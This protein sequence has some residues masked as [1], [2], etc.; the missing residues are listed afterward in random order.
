MNQNGKKKIETYEEVIKFLITALQDFQNKNLTG[1]QINQ[2]IFEGENGKTIQDVTYAILHA[3]D[4][5]SHPQYRKLIKKEFI[6]LSLQDEIDALQEIINLKAY[7][8]LP[9]NIEE[10]V[11]I[12][13]EDVE[14][15]N[16]TDIK[17]RNR[18]QIDQSREARL[19]RA[20]AYYELENAL[21]EVL[22]DNEQ[23]IIEPERIEETR[24]LIKE[25][26]TLE[27]KFE[28]SIQK[29]LQ[30]K[31]GFDQTRAQTAARSYITYI[32]NEKVNTQVKP[33]LAV[34]ASINPE[35][36]ERKELERLKIKYF[37]N[38]RAVVSSRQ[39]RLLQE[40]ARNYTQGLLQ[41]SENKTVLIADNADL[42]KD[43][44]VKARNNTT[45]AYVVSNDVERKVDLDSEQI[46]LLRQNIDQAEKDPTNYSRELEERVYQNL[47][48]ISEVNK[49][50]DD[51]QIRRESKRI[52]IEQTDR[53]LALGKQLGGSVYEREVKLALI[54]PA[55]SP[56]RLI[57]PINTSGSPA[58]Q[59]TRDLQV[60][61]AV[62]SDLTR[63]GLSGVFDTEVIYALNGSPDEE[64]SL[65]TANEIKNGKVFVIDL[66]QI[67]QFQ[68]LAVVLK[69]PVEEITQDA[70]ITAG[71]TWYNPTAFTFFAPGEAVITS[72]KRKAEEPFHSTNKLVTS[73]RAHG[74]RLTNMQAQLNYSA[75]TTDE[76]LNF[77][78]VN[79]SSNGPLMIV[80]MTGRI[81]GSVSPEVVVWKGPMPITQNA[82]SEAIALGTDENA[83]IN[84]ESRIPGRSG[85][86]QT[87]QPIKT[88]SLPGNI[89]Q[90]LSNFVAPPIRNL[91]GKT[92]SRLVILVK[93]HSREILGVAGGALGYVVGGPVGAVVGGAAGVTAGSSD[94]QEEIDRI[95]RLIFNVIRILIIA[96]INSLAIPLMITFIGIP[97]AVTLVIFIINSGAYVVPPGSGLPNQINTGVVASGSCPVVGPV[98]IS[99]PSYDPVAETGH[100]SNPYWGSGARCT[101]GIPIPPMFPGCHGPNIQ[102]SSANVCSGEANTCPYYGF[103]A[104]V[105]DPPGENGAKVVLPY[106]CDSGQTNCPSLTWKL[107]YSTYNCGGQTSSSEESCPESNRWG[108]LAIFSASGN[109]HTW[110]ID[111]NHV[112]FSIPLTAGSTYPSGTELGNRTRYLNHVHIELN[113]DETPVKPDFLCNGEN[114]TQSPGDGQCINVIG[115]SVTYGDAL[116][117]APPAGFVKANTGALASFISSSLPVIDRS[118]PAAAIA[119]GIS[120]EHPSYFSSNQYQAA[121]ND[122]CQDTIIGPWVNDLSGNGSGSQ[123]VNM[124]SKLAS[125]LLQNN[126]TGHIYVLNYYSGNPADFAR[127]TWASGFTAD[128]IQSFNNEI[129]SACN[130]GA[131]SSSNITCVDISGLGLQTVGNMSK[132]QFLSEQP[133]IREGQSALNALSNNDQMFGDGVHL[134]KTGKQSLGSFLSG[135]LK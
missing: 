11:A 75:M 27:Q 41:L 4:I 126:S 70:L 3:E 122:K 117:A 119:G 43:L 63:M 109:G 55:V 62:R 61:L 95:A 24:V 97:I 29:K 60:T 1:E 98:T 107:E 13:E 102:G 66:Q 65:A 72:G 99:E 77:V 56:E 134:S 131:L 100:G 73:F 19:K 57:D 94:G 103:A 71:V 123:Q 22:P 5:P 125:D 54:E 48:I 64:F 79:Y 46:K 2:A 28:E 118:V 40:V 12:M 121:I 89:L 113:I 44:G 74:L 14:R 69:M 82:G 10:M 114:I 108:G 45:K 111:L 34:D 33:V 31:K 20:I 130:G 6:K 15:V 127:N 76:F 132:Q 25:D 129:R 91:F 124:L 80:D 26:K 23:K 21:N 120:G 104:D 128:R 115:D 88:T 53:L 42:A 38:P 96:L 37:N 105:A 78:E 30:D 90:K 101:Y 81:K 8:S 92:L 7:T 135:Q 106:L 18:L 110:K 50:L 112:D 83:P 17:E 116:Y 52:A 59:I 93:S 39:E 133:V 16:S 84:L 67:E 36:F 49:I 35:D 47:R 9:E 85:D 68:E 86:E 32:K 87:N 58:D 51:K